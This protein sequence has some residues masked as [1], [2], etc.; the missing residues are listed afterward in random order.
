M[1]PLQ[2]RTQYHSPTIRQAFCYTSIVDSSSFVNGKIPA[3]YFSPLTSIFRCVNSAYATFSAATVPTQP[4]IARACKKLSSK[5]E[6]TCKA[7]SKECVGIKECTG[8][9]EKEAT[10]AHRELHSPGSGDTV[11]RKEL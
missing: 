5:I 6:H 4:C 8:L 10:E 7:G 3:K 11:W 1:A 2:T 9:S